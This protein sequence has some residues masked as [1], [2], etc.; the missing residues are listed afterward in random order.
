MKGLIVLCVIA[1]TGC[2]ASLERPPKPIQ[3]TEDIGYFMGVPAHCKVSFYDQPHQR[4]VMDC[5]ELTLEE[6]VEFQREENLGSDI[7]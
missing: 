4:V 5:R 2:A 7:R 6:L 1:L 3:V